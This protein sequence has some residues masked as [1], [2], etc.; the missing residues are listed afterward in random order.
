M[1]GFSDAD[2]DDGCVMDELQARSFFPYRAKMVICSEN[3]V[4]PGGASPSMERTSFASKRK[5]GGGK[6]EIAG[7][8]RSNGK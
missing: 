3:T 1:T 8:Q 7:P 5:P 2:F 4:S 6:A